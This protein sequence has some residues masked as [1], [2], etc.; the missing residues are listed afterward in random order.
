MFIHT[1]ESS[2][3]FEDYIKQLDEYVELTPE[4]YKKVMDA[5]SKGREKLKKQ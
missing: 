3:E 2:E 5:I 4:T 1:N